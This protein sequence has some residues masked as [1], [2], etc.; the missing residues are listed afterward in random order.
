MR[1]PGTDF[2]RREADARQQDAIIARNAQ[3]KRNAIEWLRRARIAL[4]NGD[5]TLFRNLTAQAALEVAVL[6]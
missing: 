2:H 1:N 4:D 6:G 3:K 5:N